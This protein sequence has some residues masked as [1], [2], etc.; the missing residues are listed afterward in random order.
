MQVRVPLSSVRG[1]GATLEVGGSGSGAGAAA[2][3]L[4]LPETKGLNSQHAVDTDKPTAPPRPAV[5][6]QRRWAVS[7]LTPLAELVTK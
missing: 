5:V 2:F 4:T 3:A 1:G 7:Y 6:G